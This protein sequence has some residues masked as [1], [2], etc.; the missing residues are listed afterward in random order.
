MS[1]SRNRCYVQYDTVSRLE[2]ISLTHKVLPLQIKSRSEHEKRKT[3][4]SGELRGKSATLLL[5]MVHLRHWEEDRDAIL[6]AAI[7]RGIE[8]EGSSVS[9]IAKDIVKSTEKREG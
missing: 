2:R 7:K 5:I 6:E 8:T 9:E 4:N 3:W 1:T